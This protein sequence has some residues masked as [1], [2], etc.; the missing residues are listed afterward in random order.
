M[1]DYKIFLT[2]IVGIITC[3]EDT[4]KFYQVSTSEKPFMAAAAAMKLICSQICINST[5]EI[6]SEVKETNYHISC[7][8]LVVIS[9]LFNF[10]G[11]I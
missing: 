4:I 6:I 3:L 7:K 11:F 1:Y 9:N 5:V 8:C 10:S 2:L